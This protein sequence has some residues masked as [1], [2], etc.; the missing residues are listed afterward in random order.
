MGT[1]ELVMGLGERVV[2]CDEAELT[3]LLL[4]FE[5]CEDGVF[6]SGP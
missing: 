5:G 2:V 1:E 6:K 4:A 3:L